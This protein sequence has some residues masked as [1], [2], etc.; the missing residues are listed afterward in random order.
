MT[1]GSFIDDI[2]KMRDFYTL[3]KD[4]FLEIYSYLTEAE[5]EATA[6]DAEI[7][8]HDVK[9]SIYYKKAYESYWWERHD[10]CEAEGDEDPDYTATMLCDETADAEAVVGYYIIYH[11][12]APLS[13][14][15]ANTDHIAPGDYTAQDLEVLRI[16][17]RL[18]GLGEIF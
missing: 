8:A 11:E 15:L 13:E 14:W 3:D 4:A 9:Y 17:T 10:K 5:Y 16:L 6:K 18:H 2:D 7:L 12:Q 1:H